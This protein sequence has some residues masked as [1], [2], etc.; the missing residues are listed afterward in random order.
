[1]NS[2]ISIL[3]LN[4][5]EYNLNKAFF[6]LHNLNKADCRILKYEQVN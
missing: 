3:K 5:M 2:R 1:M 4:E 6:L